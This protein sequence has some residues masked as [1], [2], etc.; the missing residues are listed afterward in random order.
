MKKPVSDSVFQER[1]IRGGRD[2]LP[3]KN[4][5]CL[6]CP[7]DCAPKTSVPYHQ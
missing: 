6:G 1:V 5:N 3:L 2:P 4:E 7:M